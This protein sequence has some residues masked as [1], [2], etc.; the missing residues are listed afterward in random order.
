ME[1]S[2]IEITQDFNDSG[3]ANSFTP[4]PSIQNDYALEIKSF[5]NQSKKP[6]SQQL[7]TN[8]F[9]EQFDLIMDNQLLLHQG[10]FATD[11]KSLR[12]A[13]QDITDKENKV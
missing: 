9:R 5:N 1:D 6:Y 13:K 7:L 12:Q 4:L 11:K 2:S 10:P 8:L 3:S